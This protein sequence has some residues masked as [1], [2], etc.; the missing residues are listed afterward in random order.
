[1]LDTFYGLAAPSGGG[2]SSAVFGLEVQRL[3]EAGA[4]FERP[5]TYGAGTG[6]TYE[7]EE[8]KLVWDAL[9]PDALLHARVCDFVPGTGVV[10][11]TVAGRFLVKA[12]VVIDATGDAEVAWRA[13]ATLERPGMR[14]QP[15]TATFRLGGV[16]LSATSTAELHALMADADLPR[17]EGSV[18]RTVNDGIVHTN[19]T[20]VTGL[21]PT[22][23]VELAEAERVG[24]G[25]SA[26]TSPSCGRRSRGTARPCCSARP[27]VLSGYGSHAAWSDDM[28]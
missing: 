5:N 11:E 26:T 21:D 9:A 18:H 24:R 14:L 3:V 4:T 17:R 10:V 22:D 15:M 23:P 8:L 13:G 6:V 20:R 25:R 28:S 7:P 16:D 2:G 1:M 12:Q 19:L 27:Y